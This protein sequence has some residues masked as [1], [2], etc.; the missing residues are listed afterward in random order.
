MR[1]IV[2][3]LLLICLPAMASYAAN[4]PSSKP[5]PQ[6]IVRAN[7]SSTA[8]IVEKVTPTTRLVKIIKKGDWLKVGNAENGQVGWINREQYQKAM[9]AY[10]QPDVQ[11]V[12]IHVNGDGSHKTSKIIA[13]KNGKKLSEQE[14]DKLYKRIQHEQLKQRADF[15]RVSKRMDKLMRESFDMDPWFYTNWPHIQKPGWVQPIIVIEKPAEKSKPK[16][17]P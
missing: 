7:P 3:L 5:K 16:R 10:Y 12:F 1:R 15:E 8:K 11:T 2:L 17:K 6:I 14:A 9:Q 13:Y 4:K